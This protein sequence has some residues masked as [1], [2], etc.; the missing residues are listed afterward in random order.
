MTIDLTDPAE[1]KLNMSQAAAYFAPS[2][3]A[4]K[5]HKSRV[6]RYITAGVIGPDGGRV[7]LAA[8]RQGTQWVTT[9]AAIQAFA[10]ALTP[11]RVAAPPTPRTSAARRKAAERA[12]HEL[13]KRGI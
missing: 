6:V 2:R 8:L 9:P 1:P 3:G 10:E 4:K 11:G 5:P 7:Y 12:G 13:A